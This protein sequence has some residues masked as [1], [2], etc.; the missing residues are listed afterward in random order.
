MDLQF[1]HW[2]IAFAVLFCIPVFRY[3][4]AELIHARWAMVGTVGCLIPELCAKYLGTQLAE[5]VWWKAGSSIYGEGGLNY[6]GNPALVH[7][8]SILVIL[9]AQVLQ[10]DSA[11]DSVMLLP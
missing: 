4:E 7:A 1:I 3:R 5:P 6:L 10:Q 8:R 2:L 11:T 9:F